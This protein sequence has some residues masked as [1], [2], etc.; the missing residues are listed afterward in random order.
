MFFSRFYR[1]FFHLFQVTLCPGTIG[2]KDIEIPN[3]TSGVY[4]MMCGEAATSAEHFEACIE[5]KTFGPEDSV[6][7]AYRGFGVPTAD[8]TEPR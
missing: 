6:K 5:E 3:S 2:W 1:F 4:K 7:N 8:L